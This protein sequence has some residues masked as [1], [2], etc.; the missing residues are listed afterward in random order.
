MAITAAYAVDQL[1]LANCWEKT[2]VLTVTL[3]IHQNL[4][5]QVHYIC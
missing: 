3:D 1:A 5:W 2:N 4:R